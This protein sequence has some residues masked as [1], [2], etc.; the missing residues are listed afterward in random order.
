MNSMFIACAFLLWAFHFDWPVDEHGQPVVRG[1]DDMWD[2][3]LIVQPKRFGVVLKPRF[4]K[5][6]ERLLAAMTV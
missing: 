5:L 3:A 1:V 4:D 2:N 6:E